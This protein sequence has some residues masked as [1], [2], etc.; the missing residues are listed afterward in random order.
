MQVINESPIQ[1]GDLS[2]PAKNP[3]VSEANKLVWIPSAVKLTSFVS[4]TQK[5]INEKENEQTRET[6]H[7]KLKLKNDTGE[8]ATKKTTP[9]KR[10]RS[11]TEQYSEDEEIKEGASKLIKRKRRSG[12]KHQMAA[13]AACKLKRKKCDGLYPVC[14][15]CIKRGTECTIVDATT[16][17]EIPRNYIETLEKNIKNLQE[18]TDRFLDIEKKY[19]KLLKAVNVYQNDFNTEK[20]N[21]NSKDG[22]V[23][24]EF[25]KQ[26]PQETIKPVDISK[27]KGNETPAPEKSKDL[28][29]DIGF[30]TL[31]ATSESGFLGPSSA[32]SIAKAI[33]LAIGGRSG[34]SGATTT[35]SVNESYIKETME[36]PFKKPTMRSG[37][38]YLTAYK[39]FVH[40]QYPF[41]NW[42]SI[43]SKFEDVIVRDSKD[44]ESLFF[45][46]MIFAIGCLL[47]ED[48]TPHTSSIY[49]LTFYKKAFENI[50][51]IVE[52]SNLTTVQA[53]LLIAV[54]SQKIPD[55]PSIWQT[56]GLA[57]RIAVA[58]GLHREPYK[59]RRR[60]S[61]ESLKAIQDLKARVFWSAYGMERINGLVL[62]RPF[63]IADI[64]IDAPYPD[65]T[66]E[67][68]VAIHVIRLRRIQSN[69]CTF[70]YK[71]HKF[72]DNVE[73]IDAT[74]VQILL[75]LKDWMST[76]P[77]KVNPTST[78][79]TNNWSIVSYH[80][81]VLLLLRPVVL[82][83]AKLKEKSSTRLLEWF[84]VFTQSASS[85]CLNYKLLHS[86]GKL[87]YTWMTI[88]CCFVSG[89]S[90][91]YCL[92]LDKSLKLLQ[93][94]SKSHIYDTISACS[95]ILYVLAE[96]WPRAKVFRDTFDR[97]S[98][99]VL[100]SENGNGEIQE[101]RKV[102]TDILTHGLFQG[103]FGIDQYLGHTYQ[104][105]V[106]SFYN[107]LD[108]ENFPAERSNSQANNNSMNGNEAS[109]ELY[110]NL[111]NQE[112]D[113]LL[114]FLNTSGDPL[115]KDIFYEIE[116]NFSF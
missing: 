90:F 40:L 111:M 78:Y 49:T 113:P 50:G 6:S 103:N 81:C 92:W 48:S 22:V 89:M 68:A 42:D 24:Q 21:N 101:N 94:R 12:G 62:G 32:C 76:F 74:R 34:F 98:K 110:E 106:N 107:S 75:E 44:Q 70:V 26:E 2:R 3:H 41:L 20:K 100:N 7:N 93:W 104:L 38:I 37:E 43:L 17:R 13:C 19:S 60:Q 63:S 65:D 108:E 15:G 25:H 5:P 56:T 35:S 61:S 53:Y 82:A 51:Q 4:N 30:L 86:K 77:A 23:H 115:L 29:S 91:M 36:M 8:N 55:G 11:D 116:D 97:M 83:I 10:D 109:T 9:T 47:L 67:N 58:L 88:H 95:M 31:N 114:D 87:S 52:A 85:I 99:T 73:E 1:E 39:N 71:P 72:S 80:N 84:K 69:I 46:Y 33:S 54:F 112:N 64:D 96:K 59:S 28:A 102:F 57:I 16:G 45:I 27:A 105:N 79:D 18:Q 66:E 14:S